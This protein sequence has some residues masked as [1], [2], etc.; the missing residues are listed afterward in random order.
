MTANAGNL[1]GIQS[2]IAGFQARPANIADPRFPDLPNGYLSVSAEGLRKTSYG[3]DGQ[4]D[5]EML[6]WDQSW[7]HV[8]AIGEISAA[9]PTIVSNF[10]GPVMAVV[11]Q[12][13][14][15]VCGNGNI[16]SQVPDCGVGPGSS[17]DGVRTLFPK[18]SN[19]RSYSPAGT[20][21]FIGSEYAASEMF[22]AVHAWLASVGF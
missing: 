22:G 12:A 9:K 17:A 1:T 15:I 14:Q 8:F 2:A 18:A 20:S 3:L 21:H 6:A 11:G 5:P 4:F 16:L 13:D 7:P 10:T 19:F